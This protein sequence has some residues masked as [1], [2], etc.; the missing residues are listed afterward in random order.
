MDKLT[1]TPL[2]PPSGGS[3]PPPPPSD[4]DRALL[5]AQRAA[6]LFGC[7]R[8]GDANDP[9]IYTAAITA[10]LAEYP[11]EVIQHVTDPRTGIARKIKFLPSIPELDEACKEY[12][13]FIKHRD[14]LKA[15]GWRL[16]GGKWIPPEGRHGFR[17][18]DGGR[19]D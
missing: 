2:S 16:D 1:P 6:I 12:A 3:S 9:E 18:V 19:K 11:P 14:N 13:T 10:I 17:C 5:A 7:Y 15:R 8:R 4:H